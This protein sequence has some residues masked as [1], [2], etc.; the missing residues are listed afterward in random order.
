LD[1]LELLGILIPVIIT[2]IVVVRF[3]GRGWI[4][5]IN[6]AYSESTLQGRLCMF[7][8]YAIYYAIKRQRYEL[9]SVINKFMEAG[10]AR[11][12]EAAHACWYPQC[13]TKEE[14]AE[15]IESSRDV[16]TGYERLTINSL[17]TR[18][19]AGIPDVTDITDVIAGTK[20]TEGT[21]FTEGDVGGAVIYTGGKR[22]PFK[23]RLVKEDDVWKITSIKIGSTAGAAAKW[24]RDKK[25]LAIAIVSMV[26]VVLLLG[27][28]LPN[29]LQFFSG[30]NTVIAEFMEAG[31]ARNVEAAYACWSPQSV[32][33]EEIDEYIESSYDVFAGYERVDI[34]SQSGQSG[35]GIS[36]AYVKGA[37][38]YTG[39]Q[40]L[41]LEASLVKDSDVWKITGVRI[42]STEAG[43]VKII[44]V[45]DTDHSPGFW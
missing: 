15:L 3:F 10:V 8:L 45:D 42:G 13:A 14:I 40:R 34:N 4:R 20:V 36:E 28:M 2:A 43:T 11:N 41:P 27:V 25:K 19:V 1:L 32:T 39:G 17:G 18:S 44:Y 21:K 23:A 31:V 29:L 7:P 38:I 12:V 35:G 22:L 33:E 16:L 37:I 30:V 26:V 9:K 5:T 24:W 6:T